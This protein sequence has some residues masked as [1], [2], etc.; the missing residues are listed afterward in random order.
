MMRKWNMKK[1][2]VGV[3]KKDKVLRKSLKG[4]KEK[5]IKLLLYMEEEVREILEKM[6][7]KRMEKIIGEKEIMEKKEMIEKWKEKGMD[8]RRIL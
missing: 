2:K 1:W 7:L 8:L 5:V 3:E 6:G 4:K